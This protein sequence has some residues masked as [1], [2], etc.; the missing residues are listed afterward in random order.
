M[1]AYGNED[2]VIVL[3]VAFIYIYVI[4][5]IFVLVQVVVAV[6]LD[7]FF[8]VSKEQQNQ[9]QASENNEKR[10]LDDLLTQHE[11]YHFDFFLEHLVKHFKTDDDLQ[12]RIRSMFNFLDVDRSGAI[13]FIELSEG[14]FR[15]RSNVFKGSDGDTMRMTLDEWDDLTSGLLSANGTLS[16]EDFTAMIFSRLR[17]FVQRR[18]AD[19]L[20]FSSTE[21]PEMETSLLCFKYFMMKGQTLDAPRILTRQPLARPLTL[22][23]Q[24]SSQANGHKNSTQTVTETVMETD[25]QSVAASMSEATSSRQLQS[26]RTQEPWQLE[27]THTL[28]QEHHP[29]FPLP[30]SSSWQLPA[31]LLDSQV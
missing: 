26:V 6:L 18:T 9:E 3:N 7:N 28:A 31:A 2:R 1:C 27:N 20:K 24:Q 10:K 25:A 30:S 5:I 15:L 17:L 19:V 16:Y 21:H 29:A 22:N 14:M 8:R 12:K 4:V 13:D 23:G 11:R